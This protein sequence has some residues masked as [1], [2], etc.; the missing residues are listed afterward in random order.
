MTGKGHNFNR[1]RGPKP[2][3]PHK[4]LQRLYPFR[5]LDYVLARLAY[6]LFYDWHDP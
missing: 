5:W 6:T 1:K 2:A 3:G 4:W